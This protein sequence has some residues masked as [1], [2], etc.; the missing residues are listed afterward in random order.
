MVDSDC[1]K[2]VEVRDAAGSVYRIPPTVLNPYAVQSEAETETK[3][4]EASTR[5]VALKA[6]NPEA[7]ALAE[8]WVQQLVERLDRRSSDQRSE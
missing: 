1:E 7:V 2:L 3:R 4:R 6:E 5:I 8:R